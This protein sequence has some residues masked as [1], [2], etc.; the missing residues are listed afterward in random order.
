VF[1]AHTRTHWSSFLKSYCCDISVCYGLDDRGSRVRFPA[2][3]LSL[4]IK[5][6]GREADHSPPSSAEVK[7]W[8][9]IYLHSPNT[10]WRGAE[11]KHRDKFTFAFMRMHFESENCPGQNQGWQN[12][13]VAMARFLLFCRLKCFHIPPPLL[14]AALASLTAVSAPLHPSIVV[15]SLSSK[16]SLGQAEWSYSDC[17][18]F[19]EA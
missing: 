13:Y 10:P 16:C 3:A 7:E 12:D 6:Q 15:S 19:R 4:G 18:C 9:E 1:V 17:S 2:V 11:L 8:V 14:S 5:R